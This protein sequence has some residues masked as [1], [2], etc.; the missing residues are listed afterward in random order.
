VGEH[1]TLIQSQTN[2][3]KH[4]GDV[5]FKWMGLYEREKDRRENNRRGFI[6]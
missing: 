5:S 3:D 2:A 4:W 1:V 6:D